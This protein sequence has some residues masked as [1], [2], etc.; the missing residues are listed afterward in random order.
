[1]NE[2]PSA[3]GSLGFLLTVVPT[4]LGFN[5]GR[6]TVVLNVVDPALVASVKRLGVISPIV[7][8]QRRQ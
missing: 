2:Q 3:A 8:P 5:P 1:M 4:A 6:H 7:A